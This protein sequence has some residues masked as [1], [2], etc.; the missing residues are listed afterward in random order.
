MRILISLLAFMA[1]ASTLH[2]DTVYT[3]KG[4][5]LKGTVQQKNGKVIV[6]TDDKTVTLQDADVVH[7]KRAPTSRPDDSTANS[8][9]PADNTSTTT[10]AKR[11]VSKSKPLSLY[12][13][14]HFNEPEL[15]VF[16]YQRRAPTATRT[17]EILH[18]AKMIKLWR[19]NAQDRKRRNKSIWVSPQAFI[20]KREH[21]K[22][23]LT[24][25]NSLLDT[26]THAKNDG[27]RSDHEKAR[28]R[29]H[30]RTIALT[31]MHDAAAIWPDPLIRTFL[32]GIA[33]IQNK[34]PL[35]ANSFFNQCI[36]QAPRI[37]AFHQAHGISM[38]RMKQPTR[39][40]KHFLK[41]LQLKPDSLQAISHVRQAM[42]AVPGKSV[43]SETYR[44]AR[45]IVA[46]YEEPRKKRLR[47]SQRETVTWLMPFIS[48]SRYR[49]RY[50]SGTWTAYKDSLPMP[51]HDRYVHRQAVAVAVGPQT[52][53]VDREIVDGALDLYLQIDKNT[54]IPVYAVKL[55]TSRNFANKP[56]LAIVTTND[57][58]FTPAAVDGNVQFT[59][60]AACTAYAANTYEV[61]G[62]V[63]RSTQGTTR[64]NAH[65]APSATVSLL[66]G[67]STSPVLTKG[68][69]LIGFMKGK[70]DIMAAADI[71]DVF[72]TLG[73][74][75][76]TIKQATKTTRLRSRSRRNVA[77]RM[78]ET[79]P[80][81]GQL[82][83]LYA[84]H[85]ERLQ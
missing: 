15:I 5:V 6:V 42:K 38:L 72:I 9:Y 14:S 59:K 2:A 17:N 56:P 80:V 76:K 32:R 24:K 81:N 48:Y 26:K 50:Q 39:A 85:G 45:A 31:K 49:S 66:P 12:S 57:Y 20:R 68:G 21:F 82:F 64:L 33:E 79:K 27:K 52:L 46:R 41:V 71:E 1:I 3:V 60:R 54:V 25:I 55:R 43:E 29:S 77:K 8:E 35:K 19:A 40:L 47:R 74:L 61:M 7:I 83:I 18:I 22:K 13:L 51:P 63:M 4:E 11:P 37:A 73:D 34:N 62:N 44:K 28:R 75:A 53:L 67:E 69:K 10:A 36:R 16:A 65:G 84:T 23:E 58:T 30:R 78:I 70:T